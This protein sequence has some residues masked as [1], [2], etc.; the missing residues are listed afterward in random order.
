MDDLQTHARTALEQVCARGDL[1]R[2]R[3]LDAEHFIDHVNALDFNGQDGIAQSVALYVRSSP[4]SR[5]ASSTS[6]KTATASRPGGH[7]RASPATAA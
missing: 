1:I 2:A 5:S 3:E 7:C 6:T 4:T